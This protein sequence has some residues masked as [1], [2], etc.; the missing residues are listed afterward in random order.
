MPDQTRSVS[1]S[2]GPFCSDLQVSARA[3]VCP[4]WSKGSSGPNQVVLVDTVQLIKKGPLHHT[5]ARVRTKTFYLFLR[6]R[7]FFLIA[8]AKG[9]SVDRLRFVT[10]ISLSLSDWNVKHSNAPSHLRAL[11]HGRNE[12]VQIL[13]PQILGALGFVLRQ[14]R[15]KSSRPLFRCLD[16]QRRRERASAMLISY[17]RTRGTH[18]ATRSLRTLR[19]NHNVTTSRGGL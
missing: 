12:V 10:N 18:L 14:L 16:C 13:D 7:F 17:L 4:L 5:C 11:V 6:T 9:A 2:R 15:F 3:R 1:R 8:L 19:A